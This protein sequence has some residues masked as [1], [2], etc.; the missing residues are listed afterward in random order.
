M[1]TSNELALLDANVLIY[2]D[3]EDDEHHVAAKNRDQE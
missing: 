3:Q 1:N 2:A